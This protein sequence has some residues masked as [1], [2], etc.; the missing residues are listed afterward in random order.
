MGR[1]VWERE[2]QGKRYRERVRRH[3]EACVWSMNV[4]VGWYMCEYGW[5]WVSECLS[6]KSEGMIEYVMHLCDVEKVVYIYNY[7]YVCVLCVYKYGGGETESK[8][9]VRKKKLLLKC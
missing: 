6:T 4:G 2:K 1:S 8:I 9:C 7:I 5:V 3:K